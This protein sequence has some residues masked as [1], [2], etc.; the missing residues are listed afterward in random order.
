[1]GASTLSITTFRI[2]TLSITTLSIMGLVKT[3]ITG[4]QHNSIECQYAECRDYLNVILNVVMLN[5]VMLSD[6][7][8]NVVMLSVVA[9]INVGAPSFGRMAENLFEQKIE[10]LRAAQ[11]Y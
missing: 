4:I 3:L 10:M 9:P 5:V 1:M 2:T 11:R 6:V 8:L 7:R